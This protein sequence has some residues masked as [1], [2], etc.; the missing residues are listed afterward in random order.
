MKKLKDVLRELR[1]LCNKGYNIF[2][3]DEN[4]DTFTFEENTIGIVKQYPD[5]LER[6]VVNIDVD[7]DCEVIHVT[8]K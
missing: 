1:P 3:W 2:I 8:L 5:W 7:D 6:E 4:G